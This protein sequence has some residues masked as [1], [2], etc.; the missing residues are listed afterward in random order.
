MQGVR[1]LL[2]IVFRCLKA[3]SFSDKDCLKS[4]GFETVEVVNCLVEGEAKAM[5]VTGCLVEGKFK[6]VG[7]LVCS[8]RVGD[9][10]GVI[11]RSGVQ[12]EERISI[13]SEGSYSS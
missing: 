1:D 13:R 5:G 7:V 6:A 11:G 10:G 9:F 12:N 3:R 8:V 4:G 2:Q